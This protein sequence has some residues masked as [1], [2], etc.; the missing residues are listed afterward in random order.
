M[1][2]EHP[3]RWSFALIG[4]LSLCHSPARAASVGD[5]ISTLDTLSIFAKLAE[6][7][8]L[9]RTLDEDGPYTVFAPTDAAFRK[10]PPG[11]LDRLRQPANR[12]VLLK[13]LEYHVVPGELG[14]ADL[15]EEAVAETA[16]QGGNVIDEAFGGLLMKVNEVPVVRAD[17]ATNNGIV[18]LVDDVLLLK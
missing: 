10:L 7:C 1:F 17:I 4:V 14:F 6:E 2:L 15:D 13:T 18:H 16:L 3:R 5:T 11:T 12:A 8:G 9:M